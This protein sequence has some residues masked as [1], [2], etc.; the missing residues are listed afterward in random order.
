MRAAH[1]SKHFEPVRL[2]CYNP[3]SAVAAGRLVANFQ[4][5][6][7]R[8]SQRNCQNFVD[9]QFGTDPVWPLNQT[10]ACNQRHMK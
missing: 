10:R 1:L 2:K 9:G 7:Y 4:I 6:R 5:Q 8:I 3:T